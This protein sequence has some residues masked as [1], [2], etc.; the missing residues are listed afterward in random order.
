MRELRRVVAVTSCL[1]FGLAFGFSDRA[2]AGS[3]RHG[4][5]SCEAHIT[6]P[7]QPPP[8][9]ALIRVRVPLEAEVCIT[10]GAGS[11]KTTSEGAYRFYRSGPLEPGVTYSYTIK[12]KI[13]PSGAGAATA[14]KTV[15]RTVK[16][17]AGEYK[18]VALDG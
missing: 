5:T 17:K 9:T 15:E 16:L 2:R 6:L 1:C 4:C 3:C 11:I 13:P 7:K 14:I 10:I 8:T 18:E 12:A